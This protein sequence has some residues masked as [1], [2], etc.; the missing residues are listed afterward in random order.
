MRRGSLPE[1][2]AES[3]TRASWEIDLSAARVFAH[4][5]TFDSTAGPFRGIGGAAITEWPV[6][7]VVGPGTDGKLMA[8]CCAGGRNAWTAH[9]N[10]AALAR[11]LADAAAG[12]LRMNAFGV[13]AYYAGASAESLYVYPALRP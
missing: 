13:R 1:A 9:P 8:V 11:I 7:L 10:D 3:L 2:I 12:K 5:Q 6:V 4:W